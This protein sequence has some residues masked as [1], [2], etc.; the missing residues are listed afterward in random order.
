MLKMFQWQVTLLA[1]LAVLLLLAGLLVLI[2]PAPY[3]GPEFYRFD[4][5][6]A[7]RALDTLGMFLLILGC[8]ISWSAGLLWQRRMYANRDQ[9]D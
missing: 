8:A 3:E 7:I 6:H 4:E 5:Q 1:A 2:P 9:V